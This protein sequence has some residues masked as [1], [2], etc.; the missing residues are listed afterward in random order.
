MKKILSVQSHVAYGYVGNRAATFPLQ[1][2]GHDVYVV[3]TVQFSNHTGYGKWTGDIFPPEHIQDIIQG[4]QQLDPLKNLDGILSGYLGSA[5][6]GE[7]IVNTVKAA[8]AD[9]PAL[10]YCCDPV[11]GD[12][13]RGVFVKQDV[14]DFLKQ[15]AI[16]HADIVTPNLFELNYLTDIQ[17]TS[18]H[19]ILTASQYLRSK[20]PKMVLVTSVVSPEIPPNRIQMLLDTEAGTWLVESAKLHLDPPPNGAGDATSAIFFAKY[21]ETLDYCSALEHAISAVFAIFEQTHEARTRELQIIASQDEI[22]NP[23]LYIQSTKIR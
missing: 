13:G 20:G 16:K 7:I 9:N 22:V 18:L 23:S 10:L 19:D 14:A 4:I 21:L 6:L 3:N 12:I 15:E 8:K 5:A 17:T 11:I 2:L 1:R